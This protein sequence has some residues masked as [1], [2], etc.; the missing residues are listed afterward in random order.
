M[1][2]YTKKSSKIAVLTVFIGI[3][4]FF[5]LSYAIAS[6]ITAKNIIK[7]VNDARIKEGLKPL[8]ENPELSAAAAQKAEDMIKKDYFSHDSPEGRT[9][10]HWIEKNNYDYE[11]AG[12][13]LAM[14]FTTAEEEQKAW[15]KSPTH[16]KNI[17]SENY[18]E[19]GAAI[20][21][22]KIDGKNTIVAVQMFGSRPDFVPVSKADG[23]AAAEPKNNAAVLG[24]E[25]ENIMPVKPQEE[26]KKTSR[27]AW[28]D[29][30]ALFTLWGIL[31]GNIL[32]LA[33]VFGRKLN[34][35]EQREI[36]YLTEQKIYVKNME[37]ENWENPVEIK[38]HILHAAE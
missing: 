19:I 14:N 11:Y 33:Y 16:R 37:E 26:A 30:A 24:D 22:G 6:S 12:E 32:F 18:Q 28:L 4:A 36:I 29:P 1:N 34:R 5:S 17:L 38:I 27:P 8:E 35:N 25:G 15:M 20:A 21:E 23:P 2:K 9:P 7:L 10:W 3:F 13:N 31:I